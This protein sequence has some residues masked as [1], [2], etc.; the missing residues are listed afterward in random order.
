MVI[1]G[2][3]FSIL[4]SQ[5]H[6]RFLYSSGTEV[7]L[8]LENLTYDTLVCTPSQ[9]Y[10]TKPDGMKKVNKQCLLDTPCTVRASEKTRQVIV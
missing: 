6:D 5:S 10:C 4:P 1:R 7:H 9:V 2:T 8:Y 3:D